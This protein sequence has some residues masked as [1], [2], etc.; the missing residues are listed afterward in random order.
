M[1]AIEWTVK[2]P[3][4]QF[5]VLLTAALVVQF[6]MKQLHL[7]SLIG[8]L[9]IGMIMGPD[10][11]HILPREPVVDLMGTIGLIYVMF[12]AGLEI[13]IDIFRNNK[14][15]TISLGLFSFLFPLIPAVIAALAMG[16]GWAAAVLLGSVISSHT[17][18]TYPM[19]K[20]MGLLH[21]RSVVAATGGTLLTDTLALVLLA[22]VLQINSGVSGV[23]L[24]AFGP[25]LLL[26]LV[27]LLSLILIPRAGHWMVLSG[28]T[29]AEKALF[30]LVVL[31]ILASIMELIGTEKILGAFLAGICLNKTL[32]QREV[33]REHIEF[34]GHML[35]IPFFFVSTGMLLNISVFTKK[36][37]MW[38]LAG[39]LL[40]MVTI[41]KSA[42]A[43]A[44]GKLFGQGWRDQLLIIGL[45]LPQAAATLAVT[46]SAHSAGIF[47]DIVIDAVI[48]LIF[49]TCL[50]GAFLTQ[51]AGI[52]LSEWIKETEHKSS[53]Q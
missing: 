9:L 3:V 7:P 41:G 44:V 19:V 13:D 29:Q 15:E 1:L 14:Q 38:A 24:Q 28:A 52:E 42:A 23:P 45:T 36:W 20:R 37:E 39:L 17:L 43:L 16:W 18:L 27:T 53:D 2:D 35:F 51:W 21:R 26:T 32:S 5:T 40:G 6:I 50:A 49:V 4:L 34:V 22:V 11:L 8:L 47:D 10:G 48:V 12:I 46:I 25:L 31:M 33:L 30:V